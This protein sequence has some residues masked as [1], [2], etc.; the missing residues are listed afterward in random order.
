MFVE[1]VYVF[2]YDFFFVV[3]VVVWEVVYGCVVVLLLEGDGVRVKVFVV[4]GDDLFFV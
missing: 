2:V 1:D 4:D 3:V